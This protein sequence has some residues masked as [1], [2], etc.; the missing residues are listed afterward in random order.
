MTRFLKTFLIAACS[1]FVTNITLQAGTPEH[2]NPVNTEPTEDLLS[3]VLSVKTDLLCHGDNNGL[4]VVLGVG[5]VPPFVYVWS[6]GTLGPVNANL[7][8][9]V[10]TVTCTDLLGATATLN[11]TIEE[12]AELN[13]NVAA[14]TNIDCLHATGSVT[15]NTDGGTGNSNIIWAN[16]QIG[17]TLLN[18]NAGVYVAIATDQNGCTSTE[19][20]NITAD[21]DL[22]DVD[23]DLDADLQLDCN[24]LSVELDGSASSGGSGYSY[25]WTTVNGHISSGGNSNTALVDA[26]G[27]YVLHVTDSSNGCSDTES[28]NVTA[29]ITLPNVEIDA[30][31]NLDLQIDCLSPEITLSGQGSLTGSGITYLWTTVDGHIVAGANTLD[32]LIVNAEGTYV[33][34]VTNNNNGCSNTASVDVDA[35]LNLPLA[36]I[37]A[38]ANIDLQLDCLDLTVD[39]DAS[40]SSGGSGI[41]Y[42]WTTVDGH[43]LAGVNTNHAVVDAAGTY[44]L[45]VSDS[46]NGCSSTASV[47]VTANLDLPIASALVT[48]SLDCDHSSLTINGSASSQ[49]G[50]Y[51]YLWTTLDG[52][53]ISGNNTHSPTV[54]E[55][56]VYVLVVTNLLSGCTASTTV[57]VGG[58]ATLNVSVGSQ[59]NVSCFGLLNG[60]VSLNV[61]GGTGA[62]TYL[63]SN[64][65][66][67]ASIT[68]LAA[69]L[70]TGTVTD[71]GGC[72]SVVN[73]T[74][75]QPSQIQATST[76]TPTS[77]GQN[78]GSATVHA[79]GG[80]SPYIYQWSNGMSGTT[81]S[82]LATGNYTV[83]VTDAAGCSVTITV[84]VGNSSSCALTVTVSATAA[85][86]GQSNGQATATTANGTGAITYM[87]SNGMSGAQASGL[88][89]GTYSVTASD[90][91]GCTAVSAVVVNSQ[92]HTAPTVVTQNVT[93]YLDASGNA[94]LT[95]GSINNGS[96]DAC[97]SIILTVNDHV[98]DCIDV[99]T[100]IVVLT[101]TDQSGNTSTGTATVTVVDTIGA[102]LTCPANITV[103]GCGGAGTPG[104][105][106]TYEMP[107]MHDNCSGN[108]NA[109]II[110][111]NGL[112]SGSSF[113]TGTTNV[114]YIGLMLGSA[115]ATCSF[116][117]TVSGG[118]DLDIALDAPS[119]PGE[120]DGSATVTATGGSGNYTYL[121]MGAEGQTT[122]TATGLGAGTFTVV[123]MDDNGCIGTQN[124]TITNP[125]SISITTVVL[126]DD[127]DDT[128][129]LNITVT[130]GT[131]P[132]T[133]TWYD[134]NGTVVGSSEDLSDIPAGDYMVV[135][136]DAN[137]CTF[138]SG[139]L[140]LDLTTGTIENE[141]ATNGIVDLMPNPTSTGKVL[142]NLNLPHN[143]PIRVEMYAMSGV[144]VGSSQEGQFQEGQ[145]SLDLAAFAP[146][147]YLVKVITDDR[148]YVKKVM[149]IQ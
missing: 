101:A 59:T 88:T 39:L 120:F 127:C 11:V 83:T 80:T 115:P 129:S 108:L 125:S 37:A 55:A 116:T 112:S 30:D 138:S 41:S 70:Y 47:N 4:A 50:I 118:L 149:R 102:T 10:Y 72:E 21:L 75:G 133:Y 56:G 1:I 34:H 81:A 106:V 13:V 26:A 93:L 73:V 91:Q 8:A 22:P 60:S 140:T 54:N 131:G 137:G 45:R 134:G 148:T 126:S 14:Q 69:G 89:A 52:H 90:G 20:V 100:H 82:N 143:T 65:M 74:I 18:L 79:T 94:S 62:Y 28:V 84:V 76:T 64:G 17:A 85:E 25:L 87:W 124:V 121:W 113:P 77:N 142:L 147:Q 7:S 71:A 24:S 135:I 123:V 105:M 31:V 46:E 119:C 3:L 145:F 96:S 144:Q 110:L 33:L 44:I 9:G 2:N 95:T 61:T 51:A 132:Y 29:N 43:I 78:N 5:G 12:P 57:T 99:G 136:T 48:G 98:F 117:V 97:G 40:A 114:S 122:A 42:L 63:W 128:G 49:G 16:G 146:G 6:N 38:G 19:T 23:I 35:N 130:G 92:D 27:T 53:I 107:T 58:T 32:H 139:M 103:N 104:N 66:S 86:C 109:S 36:H 67:G 15:L 68:G 141:L 111:V